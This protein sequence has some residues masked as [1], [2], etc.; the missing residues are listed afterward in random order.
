[1]HVVA[2]VCSLNV[3]SV[4]LP[5]HKAISLSVFA[6]L[7]AA[8]T[9]GLT[10]RHGGLNDPCCS[11]SGAEAAPTRARTAV[12]CGMDIMFRFFPGTEAVTTLLRAFPFAGISDLRIRVVPRELGGPHGAPT[13]NTMTRFVRT[14]A[15]T[16]SLSFR[17]E[18]LTTMLLAIWCRH[19]PDASSDTTP[20]SANGIF[21]GHTMVY[22]SG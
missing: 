14:G 16:R 12:L 17:M 10:F 3:S 11:P 19:E 2:L 18:A 9:P 7:V 8:T 15:I 22:G 20:T 5:T 21:L 1:M 13:T 6:R 4:Q